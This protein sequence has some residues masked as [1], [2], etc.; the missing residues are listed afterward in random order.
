[1]TGFLRTVAAAMLLGITTFA[2]HADRAIIVLDAS[3]SMWGQIEGTPK[4]QIA[5][6]TLREVLQ[7]VPGDLELGLIAYGHR[8]KGNCAD[9]EVIVEPGPGTGS[10]IADAADSMRFLGMTPL[11]AAVRQ[12]AETLRYGEEK[13]TVVLITDG[14]ETCNADPCAL[15][16]ELE[17]TGVDFTAHVVGFGL[18]EEEGRQVACLAENTGGRYIEAGDAASL[19]EA[20]VETVVVQAE[21]E[22]EPEPE[23]QPAVAFNFAPSVQMAEGSPPLP[24]D[25]GNA[26]EIFRAAADG[27]RGEHVATEYGN[28]YKA[29]LE[30]GDYIVVA[31][32]DYAR[33]EQAVT[34]RA[35]EAATPV[36]ILD[37][38]TLVIRPRPNEG[39]DVP[40]GAATVVDYPGD[41]D[42][43]LYGVARAVFPA[44]EQQVTVRIG[45][46]EVSET[47]ALAAGET[48]ERDIIVGVGRAVLTASYVGGM[49][50]EDGGLFVEIFKAQKRI[51]GSRESVAYG[52]GPGTE[53]D[54][55]PGDYVVVARMD[56]AVAEAPITVRVG[57]RADVDVILNAGVLHVSAPGAEFIE[58]FSAAKDI[59]GKRESFGYA[60]GVE[61]QT[62][63]PA[64]DYAVVVTRG[65]ATSEG[66]AT[67]KAGERS[68]I[69]VP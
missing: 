60:Y 53:H 12:A 25:G 42:A 66:T 5:R 67:V 35:D 62:T 17:D 51:D 63:L 39:A 54:V 18:S 8:E 48:V 14:I 22:P 38:G 50:V 56:K 40:D 29:N 68:E 36:F 30:P 44:G 7:S 43:T 37:A 57:E 49:K 21:P 4:L 6:E 27:S 2:A 52:Y 34:I 20:L 65:E 11:S 1:M 15:G 32:L 16:A 64:G 19:S 13:A 55:P 59:Q 9:I 33:T 28:A 69:T 23:P 24:G 58:V 41:G 26:W 61:H 45:E 31:R 47:I 3:G 46:G 10:A